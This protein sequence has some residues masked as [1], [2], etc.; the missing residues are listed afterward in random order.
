MAT[1]LDDSVDVA[2]E[3]VGGDVFV[4]DLGEN[5]EPLLTLGL[6]TGFLVGGRGHGGADPLTTKHNRR[7]WVQPLQRQQQQQTNGTP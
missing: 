6:L 5:L 3:D 2:G 1:D 7:I 4:A